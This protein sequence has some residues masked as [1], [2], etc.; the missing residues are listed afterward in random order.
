MP[1]RDTAGKDAER[2]LTELGRDLPP[3]ERL[4]VCYP[5]D[6]NV[7]VDANGRKLNSGW[8][9]K[10][11]RVGKPI[12]TTTNAYTMISSSIKTKR[13]DGVM[14]YWRG[15]ANFG[16]GLALMVD[17]IGSGLGSK[18]GLTLTDIGIQLEPTCV[19]ETSPDNFQMWYFFSKP[20]PDMALF[21]S[22]LVCFVEKV[23]VG[24]GGD[25]TIRDVARYGRLPCGI[26]N[27]RHDDG[28][29]KYGADSPVRFYGEPDWEHRYSMAE[30]AAAFKFEIK[31]PRP[32][33]PR[34]TGDIDE[35][36]YRM[37]KRILSDAGAGER[38]GGRVGENGS[39]KCRIECPWGEEH[40]NGD[41]TGAYFRG[42]VVHA[43]HDYVFGCAHQTCRD[44]GRTWSPFI[45]KVVMP[46]VEDE[47]MAADIYWLNVDDAAWLN[48]AGGAA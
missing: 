15:E 7:L 2:F 43:E 31:K 14:R 5:A 35:V 37:A 36:W 32:R 45:E 19:V 29:F 48:V 1:D 8:F 17:D 6:A 21:K 10:P 24:I 18:G 46:F 3:D 33:V 11:W 13:E 41:P 4:M 22:F 20:E 40:G 38:S 39:G 12:Q 9:P 26:N 25:S 28:T 42:P 27:K 30:I 23:L 44:A 47:L 34:S 16:S